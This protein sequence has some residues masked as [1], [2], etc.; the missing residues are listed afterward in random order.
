MKCVR[1]QAGTTF[2]Y[3]RQMYCCTSVIDVL[4]E[5]L[6][7]PKFINACEEWRKRAVPDGT[8]EDIYDGNIWKEF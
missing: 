1:T 6:L 5:K 2:L 8:Y 4:K 7:S 3:P